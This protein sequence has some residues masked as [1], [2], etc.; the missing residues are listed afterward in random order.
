M[1]QASKRNRLPWSVRTLLLP[2]LTLLLVAGCSKK[3]E[4]KPEPAPQPAPVVAAIAVDGVDLGNQLG[5]DK[6]VVTVIDVFKPRDTIYASVR[7]SGV[8]SN[9]TLN[10]HWTYGSK[11]QVVSD[12]SQTIAPTGPAVTE[13]HIT[14][15]SGWPKGDY[16]VV[17]SL[18][19]Q[20]AASK[21][22][23]VQ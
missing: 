15:P 13:F 9:A 22:F 17:I 1:T 18:N 23:K 10:A 21:S 12:T 4:P 11:G 5:P 8:S 3:E 16:Q 20:S 19:G 6:R 7:T 2:V 14:K